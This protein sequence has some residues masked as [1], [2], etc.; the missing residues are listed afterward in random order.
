MV[1]STV[2]SKLHSSTTTQLTTYL[3]ASAAADA[4]KNHPI[5]QSVTNGPVAENIMDQHAKTQAEFSN[6]AASRQTP[7]TP[8][9]TGQPLTHY[10]GFFGSLLSWENPRA[11]GIAYASVVLFIFAARYLDIIRYTFKISYM[12][13]GITVF[14][15]AVGKALL[16]T[17]LTSQ[18]R[19]KK[20][21]TV[22]RET[23][24][25]VIGDVH[26]LLNF[27][28][29]EAQQIIFAENLF[30]SFA[31]FLGAF[32]SYYLIKIVPF[33]GLS[34]ISTSIL[35]LAPLIYKTN[36]ELIDHHVS[37]ATKVLNEQSQQV[38]ALASQHAATVTESTKSLV[39]DYSAKA[40]EMIGNA[41]GRSTSPTLSAKPAKTEEIKKEN[42]PAYKAE[43]FP[44]A[45]KEDFKAPP[46]GDVA[47]AMKTEDEPLIAS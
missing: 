28:V 33:W 42:V 14:A 46:V 31:A 24:N 6:L 35:F 23:L 29:I 27:F 34:L 19:P 37:N 39:G 45:P 3:D 43:D 22:S 26:E 21:Y 8:A 2:R 10:H 15:E 38:K 40:Q 25:A 16:S 17:G 44:A 5:T 9:A 30:M 12:V 47:A 36:Q 13:L 7:S 20:Y 32:L 11:S 18:I 4:I 1:L 41:R